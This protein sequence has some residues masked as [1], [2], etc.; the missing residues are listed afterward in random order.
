LSHRKKLADGIV[1]AAGPQGQADLKNDELRNQNDE[2]MTK[3]E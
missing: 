1:E 3:S 2:T